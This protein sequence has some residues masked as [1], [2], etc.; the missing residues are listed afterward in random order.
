MPFGRLDLC[1][2]DH[3]PGFIRVSLF[4]C[5]VIFISFHFIL[6]SYHII[7]YHIISYHII[8]YHIISYHIISYHI[9]SY[10]IISYHIISYHII[11]YHIISYHIISYHFCVQAKAWSSW[12][13]AAALRRV[14]CAAMR[15][16]VKRLRQGVLGR[17]YRA[18]HDSAL[19]LAD[20]RRRAHV[21]IARLSHLALSKALAA[22]VAWKDIKEHQR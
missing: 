4:N 15:N 21:V 9:I 11:S 14:K 22:W 13:D 19:Q 8:S 1:L 16:C 18:W 12:K 2:L 17:L 10:H 3:A 7:S 5:Y 20:L 6:I